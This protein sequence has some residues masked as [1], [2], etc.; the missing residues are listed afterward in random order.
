MAFY[1]LNEYQTYVVNVFICDKYT[2]THKFEIRAIHNVLL[3]KSKTRYRYTSKYQISEENVCV[4]NSTERLSDTF[5]REALRNKNLWNFTPN[6]RENIADP[7]NSR[8]INC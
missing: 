8:K 1:E 4:C 7:L 2:Y 6:N 3:S 5:V